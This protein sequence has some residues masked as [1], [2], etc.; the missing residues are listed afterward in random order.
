MGEA[1]NQLVDSFSPVQHPK[2]RKSL[3]AQYGTQWLRQTNTPVASI[4]A[5][6]APRS[7]IDM[8]TRQISTLKGI[9]S[10]HPHHQNQDTPLIPYAKLIRPHVVPHSLRPINANTHASNVQKSKLRP[11]QHVP[12]HNKTSI[13]KR[14]I[15]SKLFKLAQFPLL[16]LGAV[17]VGLSMQSLVLGEIAICIYTIIAL[18]LRLPS[19]LTFQLAFIS[20]LGI[21]VLNI[22][23]KDSTLITNFAVYSFLLLGVGAISLFRETYRPLSA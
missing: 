22:I 1:V 2:L 4:N 16:I 3:E 14:N 11:Y 9:K 8:D 21:L 23:G 12:A 17:I 5:Q 18:V 19:R 15:F 20:L 7:P 6:T 10:L 13:R